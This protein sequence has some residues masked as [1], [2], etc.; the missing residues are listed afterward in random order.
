MAGEVLTLLDNAS[1]TGSPVRAIGGKYLFVE[2]G[3]LGGAT[4]TLEFHDDASAGWVPIAG[5]AQT[6]DSAQMV[7]L[8]QG[9]YR[10]GVTGGTPSALY[11][12]LHRIS[13]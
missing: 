1:A 2:D 5:T 7:E 9:Q 12:S 10:A 13:N 6:S 11:A 4:I 8:P 3:T